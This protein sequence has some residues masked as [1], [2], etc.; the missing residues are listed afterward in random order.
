MT[1]FS[2]LVD[3]LKKFYIENL[4]FRLVE[5]NSGGFEIKVGESL[6]EFKQTQST[7]K[8]L[9]HFAFMIPVNKFEEAKKW[10]KQKVLLSEED[11]EDEISFAYS[12]AQSFYF[13]DPSGNIVEFICRKLI[14]PS[15]ERL[16]FSV[17]DLVKISE[18]NLT[19]N[20][21]ISV[22]RKIRE[23]GI[24]VRN[25]ESLL[26]DSLNFL[27]EKEGGCF[28]LLGPPKRRWIFSSQDSEIHPLIIEIDK[29]KRIKLDDKGIIRLSYE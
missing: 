28:I 16:G 14:S 9:Y 4:G 3:E 7:T 15:S 21:V 29:L 13:I 10:A 11:N 27:G 23:F 12:N 17:E 8:P 20:E 1:L 19:T 26:E 22:G 25:N 18:I 6:L 5:S 2:H 24:P